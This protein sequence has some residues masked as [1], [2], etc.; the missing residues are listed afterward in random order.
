MCWVVLYKLGLVKNPLNAM[1]YGLSFA[2]GKS[3]IEVEIV[4][5]DFFNTVLVKNI[6]KDAIEIISDHQQRNRTVV[7]VSNAPDILIEKLAKYLKIE[8][9]ISTQLELSNEVY[10]GNIFGEIMYGEQ[11]LLAIKKYIHGTDYTLEKSWAYGDHDSDIYL[12]S[13]VG[14][15]VAVNPTGNLKNI[16]IKNNWPILNFN[17]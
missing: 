12:L 3:K 4:I 13:S 1:K 16:A 2:K 10:T 9:F 7:L 5:E 15:P 14:Y 8:K 17:L 11:K 6:F